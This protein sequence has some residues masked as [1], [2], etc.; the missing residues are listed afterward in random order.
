[1]AKRSFQDI[2]MDAGVDVRSYSG[3]GMYGR[4]C[5]GV[6]IDRG[7]SFLDKLADVLESAT[8]DEIQT[9]ADG[10]RDS[11]QDTMGLGSIIYWP[12]VKWED[13]P[14]EDEEEDNNEDEAD[15]DLGDL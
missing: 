8:E 12:N 5:L 9:I 3:R 2:L 11:R 15:D 13:D 6:D 10:I 14:S 7:S 4:E 1:M